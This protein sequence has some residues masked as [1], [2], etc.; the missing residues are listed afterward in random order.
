MSR[1]P[2]KTEAVAMTTL[3]LALKLSGVFI[4]LITNATELLQRNGKN[5]AILEYSGKNARTTMVAVLITRYPMYLGASRVRNRRCQ[6]K[7]LRHQMRQRKPPSH[8]LRRR[9]EPSHQVKKKEPSHQAKK[10]PSHQER[11]WRGQQHK[12]TTFISLSY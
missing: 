5:V 3:T 11:E 1:T 8:Q 6:G 9:K 7:P 12:E 2:A 4:Q 10:E